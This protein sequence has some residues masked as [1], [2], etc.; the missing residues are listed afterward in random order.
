MISQ[1]LQT[2]WVRGTITR[3]TYDT[4]DRWMAMGIYVHEAE[5]V[6]A[7]VSDDDFVVLVEV[8]KPFPI[9]VVDALKCY[10]P[11]IETWETSVLYKIRK[12]LW[13]RKPTKCNRP[14]LY[15]V[16]CDE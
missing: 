1:M 13:E 7:C 5:A 11:S 9:L 6:A 15:V 3:P 14:N 4:D 2:V 10:Y 16:K 12:T 8:G